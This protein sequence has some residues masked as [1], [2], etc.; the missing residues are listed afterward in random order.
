MERPLESLWPFSRA[1]K[2]WITCP[3]EFS[4]FAIGCCVRPIFRNH[5]NHDNDWLII[6]ILLGLHSSTKNTGKIS[7][8]LEDLSRNSVY[9]RLNQIW[10]ADYFWTRSK[11]KKKLKVV[12]LEQERWTIE[13]YITSYIGLVKIWGALVCELVDDLFQASHILLNTMIV[14]R[15][16]KLKYQVKVIHTILRGD[17]GLY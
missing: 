7:I 14:G 3:V 8:I 13:I 5:S 9:I 16:K 12:F 10:G 6:D 11:N 15:N 17:I 2:E 4:S 1:R